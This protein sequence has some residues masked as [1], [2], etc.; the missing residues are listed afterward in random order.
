LIFSL[1]AYVVVNAGWTLWHREGEAFSLPGLIVALIAIPTMY[2][3]ARAK[4]R[5]A[6]RLGS[7]ALGAD[8]VESAGCFY[9]SGAV[10]IG[11][12][13]QWL[14]DAWWIDAVTS[15]AIVYFLIREGREAWQD[16]DCC[17]ED[18]RL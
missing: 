12:L 8:A 1:A 4:L 18:A 5:L 11:L 15:L 9:L 17:E 2:V 3:L 13:T 14:F 7:R 6:A 10:A 16:E